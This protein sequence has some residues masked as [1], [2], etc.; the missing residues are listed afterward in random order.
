MRFMQSMQRRMRGREALRDLGISGDRI[1][2]VSRFRSA[3]AGRMLGI[4]VVCAYCCGVCLG[5]ANRDVSPSL[6]KLF[7]FTRARHES[8]AQ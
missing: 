1:E 4:A 8:T 3:P 5:T 6:E 2:C 7:A